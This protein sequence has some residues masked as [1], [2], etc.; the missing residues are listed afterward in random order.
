M[1]VCVCLCV[2]RFLEVAVRVVGLVG[3][4]IQ[5][6]ASEIAFSTIRNGK[7]LK[8]LSF[9]CISMLN[10][11]CNTVERMTNITLI[12]IIIILFTHMHGI[13]CV[14]VKDIV[15]KHKT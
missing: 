8:L 10:A 7:I 4:Q 3:W 1:C 9:G 11:E 5:A 13:Q 2:L 6:L 12:Y 15:G 14:C